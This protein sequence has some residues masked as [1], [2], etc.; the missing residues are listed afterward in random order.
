MEVEEGERERTRRG[1]GRGGGEDTGISSDLT[2]GSVLVIAIKF[3]KGLESVG[4]AMG[5]AP[6]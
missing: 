4:V 2:Q 6:A 1:R 5:F 3:L